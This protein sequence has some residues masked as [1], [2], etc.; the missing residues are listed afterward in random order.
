MSCSLKLPLYLL[1][2]LSPITIRVSITFKS[3]LVMISIVA[4]KDHDPKE[5]WG[6]KFISEGYSNGNSNTV[7]T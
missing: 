7:G 3:V 6:K 5:S 1:S 4:T 2:S